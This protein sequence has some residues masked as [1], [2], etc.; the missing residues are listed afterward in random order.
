[1][2]TACVVIAEMMR[3]LE[4]REHPL[5]QVSDAEVPTVAVVAARQFQNHHAL[6]LAMLQRQG[7]LSGALSPSR[8][9]LP[10]CGGQVMVWS[11]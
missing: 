5:A 6:A 2:V 10:R 3:A 4:H 7:S 11:E 9:G 1:M 8:L